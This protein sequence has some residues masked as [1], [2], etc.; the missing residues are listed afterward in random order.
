MKKQG[1]YILLALWLVLFLPAFL[2]KALVDRPRSEEPLSTEETY[3]SQLVPLSL[4]VI[5]PEGET[6][7]LELTDYVTGVLLG[8]MPAD[9]ALEAL[10]AQAVVARTYGLRICLLGDK[11][12][13]AICTDPGCCQAWRSREEFLENG[14]TIAQWAKI[15]SA[16]EATG[17]QVL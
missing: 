6:A 17:Q 15:R 3:G 11:H 10:K 4:S 8:E 2:T 5:L 9:F 12:S 14:G 1:K 7:Q 13:G 16:V